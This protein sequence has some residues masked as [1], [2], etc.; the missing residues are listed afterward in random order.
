MKLPKKYLVRHHLDSYSEIEFASYLIKKGFQPFFPFK[1]IG[2]DI[3]AHKKK[4]FELYQLK[5]RNISLR[6]NQFRFRVKKEDIEKLSKSNNK[7]T[8]FIFCAF[9]ENQ[10]FHFFKVPVSVVKKYFKE[11]PKDRFFK[12]KKINA[13]YQVY[14]RRIGIKIN[15]Y[16]LR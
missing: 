4:N 3:V 14:P 16:I 10:K 15:K 12:I 13:K 1:D 11:A 8:Y 9:Q 5:A 2:I 6:Y 7:N